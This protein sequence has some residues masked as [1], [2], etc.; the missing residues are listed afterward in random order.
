MCTKCEDQPINNEETFCCSV[1]GETLTEDTAYEFNGEIYCAD[2]LDDVTVICECCGSRVDMDNAHMDDNYTLCQ[3]C[4]YESYTTCESCGNIIANDDAYYVDEYDEYPYCYDCYRNEIR[5]RKIHDYSYK[6]EPIFYGDDNRYFGV[7]LE[8]DDGGCDEENAA[9]ILNMTNDDAEDKLYIKKDGSLNEGMELVSHPMSLQYHKD[10]MP[11]QEIMRKL[12]VLGYQSHK[13]STCGLHCHINRTAFGDDADKQDEVIARIIYFVEHHWAEMLKFSRRTQYQMER[14]A[15]RYGMKNKPK[16]L[17][18]DVKN[19]S[20]SRYTCVNIQNYN[21]IEFRMFRGT[22]KYNTF[23]AT[24]ELI[25]EICNVALSL[26]DE[27]MPNLSWSEFVGNL[28]KEKCSEL[29]TY[30]KERNLYINEPIAD[31]EDE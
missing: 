19:R 6:P 28:D 15:N 27:Q 8:V 12:V 5:Y 2:C 30:L 10:S 4:Y 18:D 21:T 20:S 29:I 9:L 26:T 31:E 25:D 17:M 11:W 13:T 1:C 16:E 23:V 22:L 14:W 3:E 7:E 24:L